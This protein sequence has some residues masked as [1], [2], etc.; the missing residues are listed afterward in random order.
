M[1]RTVAAFF[2]GALVAGAAVYMMRRPSTP[3]A[4]V[5]VAMSSS[6]A[7]PEP[8]E[9]S[10]P[11]QV[12]ADPQPDSVVKP[13]SGWQEARP[14]PARTPRA[15]PTNP[16][17]VAGTR[18]GGAAPGAVSGGSPDT[19]STSAT[20][21]SQPPAPPASGAANSES[22]SPRATGGFVPTPVLDQMTKRPPSPDQQ[23]AQARGEVDK[24]AAAERA[25]PREP[26]K[27]IIPAGTLINV[28]L[29]DTLSTD[30]TKLGSTFK[31]TLE[32]PVVVDRLVLAER[33]SIQEGMVVRSDPGGRVSGRSALALEL[34]K[35]TTADG[36]VVDISTES[37]VR[38]GEGSVAKDAAKVGTA[39]GIGAAIGA[40]I[41]G[42]KGAAIGAG[43]GGAA[44]AGT[45]MTTRGKKA[46][47]PSETR[48][49]F[50]LKEPVTLT[51]KMN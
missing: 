43:V 12:Q 30:T 11:A 38:E 35:L 47:I 42:G 6:H 13:R 33:G 36:Q 3:A 37:F 29:I 10:T 39:A 41:G 46:E 44:G 19:P 50:R 28:R 34:T 48:I 4:S 32:A 49:S 8:A 7:V 40:I 15:V 23:V 2:L 22:E 16:T 9:V 45:V 14:E 24:A 26:R 27:V 1:N 51:E 18:K 31:A 17:S 20:K 21:S 25:K 5:P